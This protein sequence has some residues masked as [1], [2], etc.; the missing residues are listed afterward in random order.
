[1][2]G[3]GVAL[4][5]VPGIDGDMPGYGAEFDEKKAQVAPE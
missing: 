3:A 1:V 4:G 2:P 5:G